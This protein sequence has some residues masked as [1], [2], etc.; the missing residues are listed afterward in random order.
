MYTEVYLW[1]KSTFLAIQPYGKISSIVV[2]FIQKLYNALKSQIFSEWCTCRKCVGPSKGNLSLPLWL[3][4]VCSC[5]QDKSCFLLSY[6]GKWYFLWHIKIKSLQ[7]KFCSYSLPFLFHHL[8][9][10][11]WFKA[12]IS[13]FFFSIGRLAHISLYTSLMS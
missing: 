8:L 6:L 9:A 2:V 7:L 1:V 3:H 4:N 11:D 13:W 5:L 12:T 10:I